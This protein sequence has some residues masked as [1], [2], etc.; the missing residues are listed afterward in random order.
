MNLYKQFCN[1]PPITPNEA[2]G[3]NVFSRVHR[4]VIMS[5]F[6]F[7]G[8]PHVITHGYVQTCSLGDLHSDPAPCLA[9]TGA[10]A[11][12]TKK[13]SCYFWLLKRSASGKKEMISVNS[14][15]HTIISHF[16][17]K[18][19]QVL[20]DRTALSHEVYPKDGKVPCMQKFTGE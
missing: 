11:P 20:C 1:I 12:S 6:L 14:L 8:R 3:S 16:P 4:S 2:A 17:S 10:P 13:P 7:T 15:D 9:H 19:L 5:V 18:K